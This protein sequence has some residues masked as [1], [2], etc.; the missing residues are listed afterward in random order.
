[1]I[2]LL[3]QDIMV[4]LKLVV[5]PGDYWTYADLSH[6]LS[7][8]PSQVHAS[9]A[10][11]TESRL[12]SPDLRRPITDNLEKFLIYGVKYVYPPEI[13]GITRGKLT[14]YSHPVFLEKFPANPEENYVWPWAEGDARGMSFSPLYKSAPEVARNDPQLYLALALIDALRLGTHQRENI[15]AERRLENWL[16]K[17]SR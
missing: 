12:Y 1:M 2:M 15:F 17:N 9:V 8:S 3:P 5:H 10:R 6:A 16:R 4:L 7:L 14:A 13:G 11:A